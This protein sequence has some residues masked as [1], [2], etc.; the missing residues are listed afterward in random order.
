MTITGDPPEDD[1][2]VFHIPFIDRKHEESFADAPGIRE[3]RD[4]GRV[5]HIPDLPV[6]LHL[7]PDDAIN[8][9]HAL[10]YRVAPEFGEDM[11]HGD[12]AA[13]A[14]LLYIPYDLIDHELVIVFEAQ[15]M[16]DRKAPAYID[17]IQ[18]GAD[19][20][21]LAIE[22]D[23]L[24]EL[25]PVV[26]IVLDPF[27]EE[28]M[29]HFQL[30]AIFIAFDLVH[31]EFQDI[32][33]PKPETGGIEREGGLFFRGHPYPQFEGSFYRSLVLLQFIFV[34]QHGDHILKPAVKQGGDPAG[35]G[36]LFETIANYKKIM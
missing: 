28:D 33:W 22:I 32:P 26:D 15:G 8:M 20:F 5:D 16:L 25:A 10:P 6:V 19:L 27:V 14:G 3:C 4:K 24:I 11:R 21:Q 17:G 9:R 30:K 23:H 2:L 29:K 31:I 7:L 1:T 34:I 18:L 12:I 35:I 36:F 13:L